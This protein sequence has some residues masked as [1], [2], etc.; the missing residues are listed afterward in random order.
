MHLCDFCK[1]GFIFNIK[2]GLHYRKD[3]TMVS[4]IPKVE[5]KV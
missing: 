3:G 4:W 5:N 1:K 2:T